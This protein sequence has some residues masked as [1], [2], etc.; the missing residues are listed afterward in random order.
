MSIQSFHPACAEAHARAI[1][2]AQAMPLHCQ[3]EASS[4]F[5]RL[6]GEGASFPKAK[7]AMQRLSVRLSAKMKEWA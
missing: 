6:L 1:S 2:V 3:Q 7:I 5:Y 4:L